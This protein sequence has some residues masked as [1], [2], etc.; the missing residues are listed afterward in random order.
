MAS[1]IWNTASPASDGACIT[2]LAVRPAKSFSNQPTDWRRTWPCARQRI[3]AAKFGRIALFS[4]ITCS[5]C[6][7][8][9]ISRMNPATAASSRKCA[10][11]K[12]A[13]ETSDRRSTRRPI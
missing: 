4:S 5:A 12:S 13:G 3:S 7:A 1:K 8:G 6:K 9:R 2:R 10:A 11:R